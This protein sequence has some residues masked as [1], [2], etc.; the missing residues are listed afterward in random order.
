MNLHP[1]LAN[2]FDSVKQKNLCRFKKSNQR[3]WKSKS[4]SVNFQIL[5]HFQAAITP[6]PNPASDLDSSSVHCWALFFDMLWRNEQFTAVIGPLSVYFFQIH[7]TG[8]NRDWGHGPD[9]RVNATVYVSP[10][11]RF[12]SSSFLI[13]LFSLILIEF[14]CSSQFKLLLIETRWSGI[15]H[16]AHSKLL[17]SSLKSPGRF[18]DHNRFASWH[19]RVDLANITSKSTLHPTSTPYQDLFSFLKQWR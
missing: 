5:K 16:L 3:H 4:N 7:R 13:I 2:I 10:S 8:L 15:G 11:Q 12:F 19:A 17:E 14:W 9:S 6:R 1:C 18:R